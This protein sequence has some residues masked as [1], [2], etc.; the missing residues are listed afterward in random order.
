MAAHSIRVIA[1]T[2][3]K[4][5]IGKTNI[6]VNLSVAMAKLGKRVVLLDA[7]L[8]LA[9]VDIMLGLVA[10]ENISH[11]VSG[12]CDLSDVL[13]DG[14][15]GIKVVPSASGVQDMVQLNSAQYAGLVHAFGS[16][17][18][19]ID[20]LIIDTAAGISDS[21][22][23][24]VSAA[25]EVLL[26]VCNEPTS[27]TD[28]YAVIKLLNQEYQIEKF[29]IVPNMVRDQQEGKELFNKLSKVTDRFLEVNLEH[30]HSI[31]YDD[32]VR[33][34]IKKQKAVCEAYPKS[35]AASAFKALA[36]R[37]NSVSKPIVARGNLEFF[38]EHLIQHAGIRAE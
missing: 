16:I 27:I 17:A 30:A 33:K 12:E 31:P 36:E 21:V 4:G 6:S 25:Q 32:H 9:N 28:A 24:F 29:H 13:M 2:G 11:V 26:V 15:G 19:E 14:P 7:D 18:D 23:H 8:G 3:G 37:I 38:V 35:S 5:G 22:M 10:K 20:V 34:A 1:V